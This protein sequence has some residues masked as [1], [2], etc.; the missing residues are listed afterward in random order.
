MLETIKRSF[1][2]KWGLGG[3]VVNLLF[4]FI[5]Y[6]ADLV[7]PA[8]SSQKGL[9]L[10]HVLCIVLPNLPLFLLGFAS[11]TDS[12]GLLVLAIPYWIVFGLWAGFVIER[13]VPL[14]LKA[15]RRRS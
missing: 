14:F 13:L 15:C 9:P 6:L 5:P 3:I 12:I 11:R 1:L 2:L 4:L 10:I 7:F 8:I